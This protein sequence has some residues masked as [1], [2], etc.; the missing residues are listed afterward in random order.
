MFANVANPEAKDEPR[1]RLGL[2]RGDR[3]NELLRA[4]LRKSIELEQLRGIDA[5]QIGDVVNQLCLDELLD[6]RVREA[7]DVHR[8]A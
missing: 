4:L 3:N 7:S 8:V 6:A 5:V 1:Q 2:R